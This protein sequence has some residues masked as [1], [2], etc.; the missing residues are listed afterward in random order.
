M[1]GYGCGLIRPTFSKEQSVANMA[2][3]VLGSSGI[4]VSEISL[5]TM[6]FGGATEDG[7]AK[8]IVDHAAEHGVNFIDTA[9]VYNDGR[10]E[11]VVGAAIKAKRNKWV[12]A[13]KEGQRGSAAATD[14][15]LS[16]RYVLGSAEASL[17]RLGT[18]TIDLYYIHRV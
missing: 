8:R 10:S 3:R 16:R 5:G 11:G 7:E 18:D 14:F 1:S 12:L 6:M 2:Y 15:G 9:D 17:K 4:K 13:T